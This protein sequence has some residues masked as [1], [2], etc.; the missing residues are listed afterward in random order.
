VFADSAGT[1]V[2]A[3]RI[4]LQLE[5][6]QEEKPA[7]TLTSVCYRLLSPLLFD[8]DQDTAATVASMAAAIEDAMRA[9]PGRDTCVSAEGEGEAPG[10]GTEA[11]RSGDVAANEPVGGPALGATR[12]P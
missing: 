7:G 4:H 3:R 11:V 6:Y 2:L 8:A 5:R 9:G 10:A 1:A 12:E